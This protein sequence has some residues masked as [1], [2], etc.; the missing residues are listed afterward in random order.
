MLTHLA[1]PHATPLAHLARD[2]RRKL[3]HALTSF[4]LPVT[5]TR[6]YKYAEVTAGGVPLLELDPKTMHSRICPG[7]FLVGEV[8]DVDGRLGG[9]NFQWAWSGGAAAA[10]GIAS[11][12]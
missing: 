7:L 1:I 5:A 6:G 2:A 8:L 4:D 3:L 9:F 12:F 10:A 11:H